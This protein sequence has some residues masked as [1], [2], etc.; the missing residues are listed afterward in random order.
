M[1][2]R[3]VFAKGRGLNGYLE[4]G[5]GVLNGL[6]LRGFE[7]LMEQGNLALGFEGCRLRLH[8]EPA[9]HSKQ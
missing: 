4:I 7:A 8:E 2:R 5:R 3:E 1:N 9:A 6:I